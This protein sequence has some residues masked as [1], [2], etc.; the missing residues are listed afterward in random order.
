MPFLASTR[1]LLPTY[2]GT[3][4]KAAEWCAIR[5]CVVY[6]QAHAHFVL[7]SV[8]SYRR[9]S[10]SVLSRS[11]PETSCRLRSIRVFERYRPDIERVSR[12]IGRDLS[13]W[14]QQ[15]QTGA[16]RG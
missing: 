15:T 10:G 3:T 6:G 13:P 14:L 11:S 8:L 12:L 1:A 2:R 7:V 4:I 16:R 9:R 5:S